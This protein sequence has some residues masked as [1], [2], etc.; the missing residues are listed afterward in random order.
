MIILTLCSL[1]VWLLVF[2]EGG[3]TYN[4]VC[5]CV[6]VCVCTRTHVFSHVWLFVTTWTV[7]H[8]APLSMEFLRQEY[9]SWL[10]FPIPGDLPDPG[11]EPKSLVSSAL[12]GRFFTTAPLL[13]QNS[14]PTFNF[15]F[16]P[17]SLHQC[18]SILSEYKN[19][20]V[21]SS[22]EIQPLSL[23]YWESLSPD[24]KMFL[25]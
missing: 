19:L 4:A 14:L 15:F 2:P 18:F 16:C 9:W 23:T 3:I 21:P 17:S 6:C 7:A 13:A 24:A 25:I 20:S 1:S 12:A 5:V 22:Y 11:I 8:R 10:P